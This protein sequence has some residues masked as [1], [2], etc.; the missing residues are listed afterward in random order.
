MVKAS[1]K[2]HIERARTCSLLRIVEVHVVHFRQI[3][4]WHTRSRMKALDHFLYTG[5][6]QLSDFICSYRRRRI[7]PPRYASMAGGT[8]TD[9]QGGTCASCGK[10]RSCAR[11]AR[12]R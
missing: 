12:E 6:V 3:T 7:R 10:G 5:L 8:S 4:E 11:V 2:D 9:Y 1:C